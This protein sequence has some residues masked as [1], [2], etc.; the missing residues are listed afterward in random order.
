MKEFGWGMFNVAC[1][2]LYL[3]AGMLPEFLVIAMF[4]IAG[5]LLGN[6]NR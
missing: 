4:T 1:C 2:V 5:A 6:H 3:L